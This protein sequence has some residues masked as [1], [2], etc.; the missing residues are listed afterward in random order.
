MQDYHRSGIIMS[1]VSPAQIR[2]A[3]A[4][5]N[6]SMSDLARRAHVS[7]S[8]VKRFKDGQQTPTSVGLMQNAIEI[9]GIRF[10]EDDGNGPGLRGKAP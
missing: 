1:S 6:W 5:L 4:M 2:A 8:T 10:L 3:R 9:E 7:V